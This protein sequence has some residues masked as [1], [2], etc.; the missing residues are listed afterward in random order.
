MVAISQTIMLATILLSTLSPP[1]FGQDRSLIERETSADAEA[2]TGQSSRVPAA[3]DVRVDDQPIPPWLRDLLPIYGTLF[4]ALITGGAA[5]FGF[6]RG[7][8]MSHN[9]EVERVERAEQREA[10]AIREALAA[11]LTVNGNGFIQ[12]AD[13]IRYDNDDGIEYYD[14]K[15]SAQAGIP[16]GVS[17]PEPLDLTP[18]LPPL[19]TEVYEAYIGRIHR[20]TSDIR[21]RDV[22]HFYA[23]LRQWGALSRAT[24]VAL[25]TT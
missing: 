14:G 22:I 8:K 20:L 3:V 9:L 18:L 2:E 11:E 25:P 17:P 19:A 7:T 16:G 5:Y 1:A 21:I 10:T 4:A 15:I 6:L 13:L 24:S 12:V 23:S